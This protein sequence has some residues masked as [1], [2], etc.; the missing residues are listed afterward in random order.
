MSCWALQLNLF[1]VYCKQ[2]QWEAFTNGTGAARI[3]SQ[4]SITPGLSHFYPATNGKYFPGFISTD[5]RLLPQQRGAPQPQEWVEGGEVPEERI[6]L[7]G[8]GTEL[9]ADGAHQDSTPGGQDSVP[10]ARTPSHQPRG[11][12]PG[13]YSFLFPN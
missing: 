6:C 2:G 5:Q 8:R 3:F 9:R 4:L 7:R 12:W 10:E 1:S 11:T 13:C